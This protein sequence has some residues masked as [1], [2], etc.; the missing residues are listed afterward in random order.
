MLMAVLIIPSL[1][2][3][4]TQPEQLTITTYYPSP[5]GS[6][7]DLTTYQMKIGSTYVD[8][9]YT[10]PTNGLI[11]EGNVGIGVGTNLNAKLHVDGPG[12]GGTFAITDS[13]RPPFMQIY[14]QSGDSGYL[15]RNSGGAGQSILN[16]V[17]DTVYV[18]TLDNSGNVTIAGTLTVYGDQTGA[19]DHVFDDYDDIELLKKWR[20]GESLPFEKGDILNRDRLLRDAIVQL[21][22]RVHELEKLVTQLTSKK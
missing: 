8:S 2:F 15:F 9:G 7:R 20:K 18:M 16:F 17:R 22:N 6:Y 1:A 12:P 11:I 5:F 21:T 10:A 13:T 3:A 19:A 14:N 4:Q